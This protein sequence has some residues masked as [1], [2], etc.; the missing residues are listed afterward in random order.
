[1]PSLIQPQPPHYIPAPPTK[2]KCT[3]VLFSS[4]INFN[5][6]SLIVDYADLSIIDLAKA[7]TAQGRVEL[8][9][10]VRDA[11]TTQ[12]F[13]YVINHGYEPDQV[14]DATSTVL[15]V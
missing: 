7:T 11:M 1:M 12:G 6:P 13:F 10:S 3:K 5:R 8:A 9:I 15:L 14:S 4:N 2:E